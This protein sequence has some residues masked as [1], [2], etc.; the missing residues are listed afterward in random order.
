MGTA[1][2]WVVR[3]S[4]KPLSEAE[5]ASLV[6]KAFA[7]PDNVDPV[8]PREVFALF[9]DDG[10][11]LFANDLSDE[12]KALEERDWDSEDWTEANKGLSKE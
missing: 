3:M 9:D 4:A 6:E 5:R 1:G 8:I 10:L 2:I 7:A 11:R 12:E